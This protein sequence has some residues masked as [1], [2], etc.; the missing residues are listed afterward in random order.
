[1]QAQQP[2]YHLHPRIQ[3]QTDISPDVSPLKSRIPPSNYDINI[4]DSLP[5][6][7]P[8]YN[9]PP[10]P[11]LPINK[12]TFSLNQ[13]RYRLKFRQFAGL[14]RPKPRYGLTNKGVVCYRN[15]ILNALYG[16]D[17]V[18]KYFI[19]KNG[20]VEAKNSVLYTNL[21]RFFRE[22]Q[23]KEGIDEE[24]L[25]RIGEQ[26]H[27]FGGHEQYCAYQYFLGLLTALDKASV[28]F[29]PVFKAT[30]AFDEKLN[31]Y[32]KGRNAALFDMF[33]VVT[34]YV[35]VCLDCETGRSSFSFSRGVEVSI[36]KGGWQGEE[37][38]FRDR[39]VWDMYPEPSPAIP[40]CFTHSLCALHT[41][42]TSVPP[43]LSP[44]SSISLLD[45]L[46]YSTRASL[47][48]S[49]NLLPCPHCK[50]PTRH[51][52]VSFYRHL[53]SILVLHFQRFNESNGRKLYTKVEFQEVLDMGKYVSNG[54]KYR[55]K[56]VVYHNGT[57][58]GGHYTAQVRLNGCWF[59]FNDET[60]RRLK[61]GPPYANAYLLFY[62]L[63]ST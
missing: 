43:S 15:V 35:Y 29:I 51:L 18:F 42:L 13:R 30:S 20:A 47:L 2:T 49:D 58:T 23:E 52:R 32:C 14:K 7:L 6:V 44:S 1:M 31:S 50:R 40:S 16:I 8:S 56:A 11:S 41:R 9:F 19:G 39:E 34:E 12:F 28:S 54:G 48:T 25:R 27:Q 22:Y 3:L 37:G 17:G 45:C 24:I 53:G 62:E 5:T 21:R 4:R 36:P 38:E 46:N 33:A 61:N 57:L 59:S 26:M 63:T 60:I 10:Q 55:L